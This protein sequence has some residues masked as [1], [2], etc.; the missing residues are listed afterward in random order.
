MA[1]THATNSFNTLL[2]G[3]RC[4]GLFLHLSAIPRGPLADSLLCFTTTKCLGKTRECDS[5][6]GQPIL[7]QGHIMSVRQRSLYHPG[8]CGKDVGP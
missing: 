8:L 2:Q 7:C 6:S 3:L 5:N 1:V 4:R